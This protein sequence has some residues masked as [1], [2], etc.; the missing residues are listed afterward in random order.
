MSNKLFFLKPEETMSDSEVPKFF[1]WATGRKYSSKEICINDI[2][3]ICAVFWNEEL[4]KI[5]KKYGEKL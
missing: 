5:L 1:K 2:K 3:R 4:N